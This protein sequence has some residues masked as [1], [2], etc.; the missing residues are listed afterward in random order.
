[1][2]LWSQI[3]SINHDMSEAVDPRAKVYDILK[4]FSTAMFVTV[5]PAAKPAARPM[6]VA[7][8]DEE[9]GRVWFFTAKTGAIAEELKGE[10]EVLLV[11]QNENSAYLSLRGSA[12][13]VQDHAL[14]KELWKEPYKV[15]FPRGA[16]DPEIALISVSPIGAEY[17]DN[18]GTNKLEYL[19]E[20]AKAYVKGQKPDLR[21]VEHHA[22]ASL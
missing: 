12:Q 1:M 20:A 8:L 15:W 14:I 16:E 19:F 6:H 22:K 18:R 7:R 21:A 13:V 4:G 3:C 2:S 11:F 10:A 17:W 5:S 9:S